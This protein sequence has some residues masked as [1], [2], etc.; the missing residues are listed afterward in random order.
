MTAKYICDDGCNVQKHIP[1]NSQDLLFSCPPYFDLEIYS[2]MEND[3]SNQDSYEDFIAILNTAFTNAIQCLK[4][5]RFAVIV[6]G[7]VRDKQGCYY[8]F[9]DDVKNIF[10]NGGMRLYNELILVEAIGGARLRVNGL[11]KSRK[12]AKTH[13]NILVFYKG[14][15]KE[16]TK[17]Y[18][19]L[20][21]SEIE[22]KQIYESTNV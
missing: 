14:N 10:C 3:A 16:I 20:D 5:N 19:Q 22:Q 17:N 9:V 6:V 18:P 8:R 1:L 12:I 4:D 2:D 13:Q 11:M 15:T 7:D 21:F